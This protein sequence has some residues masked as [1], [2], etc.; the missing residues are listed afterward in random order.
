ML[1]VLPFC[2]KD[3]ATAS[4]NIAWMFELDGKT[5]FECLLA[6]PDSTK[7]EFIEK[8]RAGASKV[9][10]KV[11]EFSYP[12][13]TET[14]WPAGPNWAWQSVARW[15]PMITN[16]KGNT[17]PFE[18]VL[19]DGTPWLFLEADAVPLKPGWMQTLADEYRRGGKP[20]MGHIVKDMGHMNG[21]A[22]YPNHVAFYAR[23]ALHAVHSAWDAVLREQ[24][25]DVTHNANHLIQHCWVLHNQD[26]PM[27]F[28]D[29]PA[30][31]FR[32]PGHMHRILE[33]NAVLFHRTKDGSLINC[34]MQARTTPPPQDGEEIG[35]VYIKVGDSEKLA[36]VRDMLIQTHE[37]TPLPKVETVLEGEKPDEYT[38]E[39]FPKVEIFIVT[40]HKDAPWLKYCLASIKEFA[41]GFT[42]VTVVCPDRDVEIIEP[43]CREWG[44][45]NLTLELFT[46]HEGKGMLHHMA[47]ECMADQFVPTA[48]FILHFDSDLIFIEPVTPADYF[49]DG[50]PVLLMEAYERFKDVHPGVMRWQETTQKAIGKPVQFEFMRRHPAVH[51]RDIYAKTRESVE[52]ANKRPFLDWALSGQNEFPQSWSEYNV[53]GAVA[54][55]RARP[56]YHWINTGNDLPPK[57]KLWQGWSHG[58]LDRPSDTGQFV[59]ETPRAIFK[60]ILG[61]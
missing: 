7:P 58:G 45:E 47:I 5:N 40:Y 30:P 23:D 9:F 2:N 42:G 17:Y 3:A 11:H 34:L 8:M 21:V 38:T 22:V 36:K 59:P 60:K 13:A 32:D 16:S 44:P 14:T 27:H 61:I 56:R 52:E 39:K 26:T 35:G 15:I 12:E 29:G 20:F 31:S 28:G 4:K 19:P 49:V 51:H 43:V 33:P 18:K 37:P 25:I 57:S 55:S 46:E 53:L 54:Y 48:D 1:L 6:W 41:T 24:T 50:K 10:A